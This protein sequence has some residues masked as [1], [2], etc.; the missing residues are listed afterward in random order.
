MVGTGTGND[1]VARKGGI[2]CNGMEW[3]CKKILLGLD[4]E[5]VQDIRCLYGWRQRRS[6]TRAQLVL[7]LDNIHP[8]VQAYYCTRLPLM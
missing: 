7:L 8:L 1:D 4:E 6:H 5:L 2:G 3:V